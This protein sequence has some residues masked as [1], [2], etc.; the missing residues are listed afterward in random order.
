M[1]C[2]QQD[3]PARPGP[4]LAGC[5]HRSA[6]LRDE[7]DDRELERGRDPHRADLGHLDVVPPGKLKDWDRD[8]FDPFEKDG[9]LYGRGTQ[10]DKGPVVAALFA[11]KALLDAAT[12]SEA[13]DAA[14]DKEIFEASK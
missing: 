10:D 14:E 1:P 3:T 8:P 13:H 7:R 11:V 9:M 6:R 4:H 12:Q 2:R 5:L